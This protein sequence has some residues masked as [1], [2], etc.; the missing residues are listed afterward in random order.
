MIRYKQV[1][2]VRDGFSQGSYHKRDLSASAPGIF[3]HVFLDE[4][5]DLGWTFSFPFRS[6]GSSRFLSLAFLFT[7][8]RKVAIPRQIISNLYKKY[9]WVSEKKASKAS[10]LQKLEFANALNVMLQTHP[11]IKI[12]CITVKKE[13]VQPHIRADSNKLYNYMCRLVIPDYVKSCPAFE[14]VPDKRSVKVESGNSLSDYLQTVLWFDCNIKSVLTNNPQES[15]G[16]YNLQ[17]VDWVANVTW[18]HFEDGETTVFDQVR[19]NIRIRQL[20]F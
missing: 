15:S 19:K 5:G 20:F 6:G 7:P 13:N 9:G 10:R 3:M 14:F 12:D 17:F 8:H 11:D 2:D 16:D 1:P 18:S 4:S